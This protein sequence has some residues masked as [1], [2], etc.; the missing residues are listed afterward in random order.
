MSNHNTARR[1]DAAGFESRSRDPLIYRA[2]KRFVRT[3]M[4]RQER[5]DARAE[6]QG[7]EL[8]TDF[9]NFGF[10][11]DDSDFDTT[12]DEFAVYEN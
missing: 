3:R 11:A 5:I 10:T 2:N 12:V 9:S 1:I 8:K 6:R 7:F 4:D